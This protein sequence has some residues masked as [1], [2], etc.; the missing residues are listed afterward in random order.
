[1]AP[2]TFH[3]V[4]PGV[5]LGYTADDMQAGMELKAAVEALPAPGKEESMIRLK[6]FPSVVP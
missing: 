2:A 6:E 1:V 5:E 4:K 3:R